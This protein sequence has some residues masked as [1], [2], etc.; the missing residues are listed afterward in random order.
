MRVEIKPSEIE[1]L[2]PMPMSVVQLTVLAS[3]DRSSMDEMAQIIEFDEALTANLLRLANS[4]WGRSMAPILTV[5]D[6]VVRLGTA[7]ILKFC[8]GRQ[9]A[10]PMSQPIPG[11]ELAEHELWRHSVA[12]AL[13]AEQLNT[14]LYD[15]VP[16][17]A[18]TAAL[19]HDIGKLLLGRYMEPNI[20]NNIRCLMMEEN[21]SFKIAEHRLMG[22]NHAEVGGV[23]ARHWKFPKQLIDAI[24][25]H[26][27]PDRQP[28]ALVDIV[29]LSNMVG[30]RVASGSVPQQR[31]MTTS[32]NAA[33][34]L[35]ISPAD[36]DT[37]SEKTLLDLDAAE[38][39]FMPEE[40]SV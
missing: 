11:Y 15:P 40:A 8:V 16:R 33:K 7:Q 31:D 32:T 36:L 13:A 24:E 25:L 18:F 37:A 5:K 35:V 14:F 21:I 30:H 4:V 1:S 39:F 22:T 17:L 20:L 19:M 27:D 3:N 9:I 6:A 34:R 28:D 26:H 2:T 12:S 29:H 38:K 23:M 10:A